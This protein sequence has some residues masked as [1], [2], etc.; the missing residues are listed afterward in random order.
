MKNF[1][2][3]I[4]I[5]FSASFTFL[6]CEKEITSP[7]ND[8][9]VIKSTGD[10][11]NDVEAFRSLL[12]PLNTTP[13]ATT[14][15]REINWDGVPDSL[16][17]VAL[18]LDFFNPTGD[19]AVAS[20]QRGVT[21]S[22]KGAFMV[23][24]ASFAEI[25]SGASSQFHSFSGSNTFANV[26][27]A[28]W[29]VSF[30]KAGTTSSAAVQAFGLV[31]SDVDEENSTSLEFFDGD[32]SLGKYFVPPHDATSSFSFLGV[33]FKNGEHIT[34]VTVSHD[35]FLSEGTKDISDN[36]TRDLVVL[37]DFIYSEPVVQ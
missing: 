21:Y 8:I 2:L 1:A 13:G 9:T 26:S 24:S 22:A 34:K 6:S 29:D 35:G 7:N 23:S 19:N 30:Q 36:G 16:Q 37:D 33:Y 11:Q 12:G 32:K 25:N 5:T 31:F 18:P 4:A 14:G 15:R 3:L 10:I 20:L 27:A 17:D 28:R